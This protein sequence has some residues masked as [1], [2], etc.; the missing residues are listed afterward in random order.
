LYIPVNIY[1]GYF[2]MD[3]IMPNIIKDIVFDG[4]LYHLW[5]LPASM[6]GAVISW[7]LVKK[8]G[9]KKALAIS[10]AFYVAGLCGDSYYG[11]AAKIPVLKDFYSLIFQVSGYTR[12]GIFFA[13]VFFVLGGFISD[14]RRKVAFSKSI[15]YFV[16]S[17]VLMLAEGMLLHYF[18]IQ[19]HDSMYIFLLPCMYFLFNILLHIEGKRFKNIRTA[20]LVIYIIHP[21]VIVLVRLSAKLLHIQGLL[22][23]N[24]IV[25]YFAVCLLSVIT[26]IAAAVLLNKKLVKTKYDTKTARAYIE[27]DLKSLEHNVKVL[28][29]AMPPNCEL[30]AVVKAQAYGHGAFEVSVHLNKIGIRAFAV[31]TA[32]EGIKLRKYGIVGEILVLGYTDVARAYELSKYGLTQTIID[33]GYANALNRQGVSIKCHI[34]IDTGMHRLGADYRDIW[35]IEKIFTMKNIKVCGMFTHLCCADSTKPGD[36]LFTKNQIG[37]FYN[38]VSALEEDGIKVPKLHIQSSYGFLN[39]PGL[40]CSY[41]RAGIA[42]YGVLSSPYDSTLLKPDLHPVLSLKS[43]VILIRQVMK[44][45]SVGYGRDFKAERD[46]LVAIVPAGYGDGFPRSLSCGRGSVLINQCR[47]PVIGRIC[48]DQLAIDITDVGD[49]TVGTPVT[50]VCAEEDSRLSAPYVADSYGSIS[51]ELLC[52]MGARLPVIVKYGS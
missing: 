10:A 34:K 33:A 50:L 37:K 4:T 43:K 40:K 31:A 17:F 15:I 26:G 25:H 28:K 11:I 48:M 35:N 22:I 23:E 46:S 8:H 47:V 14:S 42:L 29:L 7:H 20:S 9:Y 3:N 2:K 32:D 21:L 24:S 30:M 1:N 52:R 44:G 18:K 51:N 5:Y 6:A 38:L 39:Y 19:R 36:V 49:V 45:E 12:N 16:I 41:V 13:P 27:I